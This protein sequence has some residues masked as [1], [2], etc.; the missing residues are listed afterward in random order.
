M[1]GKKLRVVNYLNQ[2]FGHIGG[3]EKATTGFVVKEGPVGP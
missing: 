1:G 3:E 2:F